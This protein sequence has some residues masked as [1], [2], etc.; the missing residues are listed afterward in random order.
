[1]SDYYISIIS[2]TLIWFIFSWY[3][4]EFGRR[5]KKYWNSKTGRNGKVDSA[6]LFINLMLFL[7]LAFISYITVG[8]VR[9]KLGASSPLLFMVIFS[10]VFSL[11][12]F[13]RKK[14][15]IIQDDQIQ[16]SEST[17]LSRFDMFINFLSITMGYFLLPILFWWIFNIIKN[18]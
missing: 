16:G 15:P 1:M 2:L 10:F 14:R 8:L 4:C 5:V 12:Y 3:L 11:N 6:G 7:F 18:L 17:E 13:Y 9:T